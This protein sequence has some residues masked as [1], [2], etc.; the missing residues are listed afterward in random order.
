MFRSPG[1]GGDSKQRRSEVCPNL[2]YLMQQMHSRPRERGDDRAFISVNNGDEARRVFPFQATPSGNLKIVPNQVDVRVGFSGS[3]RFIESWGM[4]A[5]GQTRSD[6][7]WCSNPRRSACWSPIRGTRRLTSRPS[8]TDPETSPVDGL[9]TR[10][11][12]P[13]SSI[14]QQASRP[15]RSINCR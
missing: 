3:T 12:D 13:G 2:A 5:S 6:S 15:R 1:R 8:S 14:F 11:R 4:L 7:R 10:P 9:P